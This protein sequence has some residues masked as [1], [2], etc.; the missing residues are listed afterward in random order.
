MN[1]YWIQFCLPL[2][3]LDDSSVS[4]PITSI[5]EAS[6]LQKHLNTCCSWTTRN[7]MKFNEEKL[8]MLRHGLNLDRKLATATCQLPWSVPE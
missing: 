7:N 1:N 2:L 3:M 8:E 5:E 6:Q 4:Q